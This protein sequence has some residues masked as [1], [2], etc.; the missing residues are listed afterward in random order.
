MEIPISADI[1]K[2]E[3]MVREFLEQCLTSQIGLMTWNL[4]IILYLEDLSLGGVTMMGV[5]PG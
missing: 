3:L 1:K 4:Q 2:I 5:H